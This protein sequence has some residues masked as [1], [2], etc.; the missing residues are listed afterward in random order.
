MLSIALSFVAQITAKRESE[1]GLFYK[2]FEIKPAKTIKQTLRPKFWLTLFEIESDAM[3][4]MRSFTSKQIR[5]DLAKF[6]AI[7]FLKRIKLEEINIDRVLVEKNFCVIFV[8]KHWRKWKDHVQI[9]TKQ[10]NV[11]ANA[12]LHTWLSF[13]HVY[14]KFITE[15]SLHH[16]SWSHLET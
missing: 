16:K 13:S 12:C 11:R 10:A 5:E 7:F 4:S 15:I 1:I 6:R 9:L 8:A 14:F 2:K 3:K